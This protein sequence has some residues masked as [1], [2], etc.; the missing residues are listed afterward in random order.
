MSNQALKYKIASDPD[1]FQQI[2]SLN[3]QTFVEEI[4]QHQKNDSRKLKDRFHD[5]NTYVI[6]KAETEVVGMI[7]VRSERPFSLD[8]KLKDL[9]KYLPQHAVPCEI[10]LLSVK[11]EYRSTRVFYQLCECLV[12]YCLEM[13]Y[14]TALIS[15][16]VRQLK[17][18]KR[19]GFRPFANLVGDE[20]ARFQ[21]MY[22][23][24]ESFEN[25]TKAFQR[26]MIRKTFEERPYS[27]LPGPVPRH[28]KVEDAFKTDALS[29]RSSVFLKEME[30]IRK[31]LC[32]MTHANHVQVAVGTG[33]LANDMVAAQ[34]K[35]AAG[36]G[37]ILANGEFGSRLVDHGKRFDLSF[38]T[39]EKEWNEIIT[40]EEIEAVLQCDPGI[41]WL[42]TVHCETS[43]G[44]LYDIGELLS[45]CHK[46]NVE[47]CIDACSSVGAVPIDL[48]NVYL[49]TSVS[50]KA[51]GSYPG[52]ALIFHR[53]EMKPNQS[54]PRYL[55]V[56]MYTENKGVPYTHSSNLLSAL[57]EAMRVVDYEKN[58][59]L[60]KK[61]R[62]LLKEGGL[63]ILEGES[64]SP[65]VITIELNREQCSRQFGDACKKNGILLSYESGYLLNKNWVQIALMGSHNER[66][67]L[68]AMAMINKEFQKMID[69]KVMQ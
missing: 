51:L 64:Y 22:L 34:L 29:H 65:G 15:G 4:P 52:L 57:K 24:R 42:W 33:T 11:E 63:T 37:L 46:Y 27:L 17:L 28:K 9:D 16:T 8:Q 7:A 25:S 56:G 13:G 36:N 21:P 40:I 61:V 54:I 48:K 44:Y 68:N 55:D 67:V 1:E 49:A 3:Y 26:L 18:Y 32:E 38:Q 59:E 35:S 45:L 23:T 58:L 30:E 43:T 14:T 10:R 60:S 6:A 69:T 19:I 31:N 41:K 5:E 47:L 39:I 62:Q 66:K 53:D 2:Y 50:G 12:S 20:H